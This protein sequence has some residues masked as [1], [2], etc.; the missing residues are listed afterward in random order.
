MRC[1]IRLSSEVAILYSSQQKET[2]I[3]LASLR[4]APNAGPPK[5]NCIFQP[6]IFR[7]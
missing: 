2:S 3:Q 6:S 5:G 1:L 4:L 7:D